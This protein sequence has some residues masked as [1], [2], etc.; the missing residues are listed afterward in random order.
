MLIVDCSDL[1]L[2]ELPACLVA[3][4]TNLTSM[5]GWLAPAVVLDD[6]M[7]NLVLTS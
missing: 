6:D 4:P 2:T 7:I 5:Y 1:D 3:L